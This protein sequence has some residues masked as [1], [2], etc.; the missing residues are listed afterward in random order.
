MAEA[1]IAEILSNTPEPRL[2]DM[3]DEG[4]FD[5]KL[6]NRI[7][8][9]VTACGTAPDKFVIEFL[10]KYS[11]IDI[12]APSSSG[13]FGLFKVVCTGKFDLCKYLLKKGANPN[14]R[15]ANGI[16]PL[17]FSCSLYNIDITEELLKYN[18]NIDFQANDGTNAL[19][20]AL[21]KR[22]LEA[23]EFLLK[24]NADVD[25]TNSN[26][27]SPLHYAVNDDDLRAV[28][29]LLKY[30]PDP[31]MIHNISQ[32][33]AVYLA[34]NSDNSDLK[35]VMLEYVDRLN[36]LNRLNNF[37]SEFKK[38]VAIINRARSIIKKAKIPKIKNVIKI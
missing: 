19:M 2:L 21:F 38:E 17:I 34:E 7:D 15:D 16:T 12:N 3:L 37:T 6:Q 25:I 10:D 29:L 22:D 5:S 4:Y 14:I 23:V 27:M 36:R 31:Y 20:W 8:V 33:N 13:E 35:E 24:N 11:D 18:V 28:S 1:T 30:N 9:F 26:N 32:V